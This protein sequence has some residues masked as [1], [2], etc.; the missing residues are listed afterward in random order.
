MQS[1][2]SKER[3]M[4]KLR[5]ETPYPQCMEICDAPS[6]WGA[7]VCQDVICPQKFAA[8]LALLLFLPIFGCSGWTY[9]GITREDFQGGDFISVAAGF[10]TSYIVHTASH[11]VAAEI[12]GEHW[13]YEGLSEI[14]DGDLS[15]S[16]ARWFARAG[17]VGQLAVG[18]TMKALGADGP[19]ARGYYTGTAFEIATYPVMIEIGG[20]QGDDLEMISDND[21]NGYA[22]WAA[23][24]VAAGGLLLGRK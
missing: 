22:E 5:R 3:E 16:E 10:G 1:E 15:P 21:G 7:D 17:F 8:F 2:E 9:N 13:H 23:Y 4:Q 11:I 20:Q 24:S 12:A 14:V 19:F 18:W 6:T